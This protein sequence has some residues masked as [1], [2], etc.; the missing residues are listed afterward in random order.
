MIKE[1][2]L[3]TGGDGNIGREAIRQLSTSGVGYLRIVSGGTFISQ[4]DR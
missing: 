3:V 4:K 1:N 2:I